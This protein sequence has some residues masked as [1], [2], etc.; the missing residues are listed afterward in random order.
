MNNPWIGLLISAGLQNHCSSS[1]QQ[2][3]ILLQPWRFPP[4]FSYWPW[5]SHNIYIFQGTIP[6]QVQPLTHNSTLQGISSHWSYSLWRYFH[7]LL[8]HSLNISWCLLSYSRLPSSSAI[9]LPFWRSTITAGRVWR[10]KWREAQGSSRL[11]LHFLCFISGKSPLIQVELSCR[12][13]LF[14]LLRTVLVQNS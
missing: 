10:E 11:L 5:I 7:I 1:Y 8:S 14:F 12:T 6:V 2:P 9:F 13:L 3:S 4:H